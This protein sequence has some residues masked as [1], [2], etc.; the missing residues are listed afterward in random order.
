[1]LY[2][3]FSFSK[4]SNITGSIKGFA[5]NC[6]GIRRGAHS[7]MNKV[8]FFENRYKNDFDFFFFLETH[9]KDKNEIPN[10][11]MRYEDTHDIIHSERDEN[12]THSGIIALIRKEY[13]VHGIENIIQGRILGLKITDTKKK[14]LQ[15]ISCILTY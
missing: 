14:Y 12:E 4:P 5:W 9:H 3:R 15:S 8:L 2:K 7:T 11:L 13:K 1:M 10:E 6:G